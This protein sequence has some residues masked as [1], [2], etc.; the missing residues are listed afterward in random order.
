ME[1]LMVQKAEF[2]KILESS[3]S[4]SAK[5][6]ELAGAGMKTADIGRALHITYQHAYK[7]LHDEEQKKGAVKGGFSESPQNQLA[8]SQAKLRLGPDGRV[9][10]PA[11]FRET[12][13]LGEGDTL[14]ARIENG[15]IH[16]LTSAA[17]MRR[18]NAMV[19]EFVPE[20]V[21]LVDELI[22]ERRREARQ[23]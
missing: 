12:L 18:V 23:D 17:V 8:P 9:V 16:L 2:Q 15:E 20:G 22:E 11:A 1:A 3:R 5:I 13:G 21:S 7:V 14:F 6:R 19:R 4:K 10:I